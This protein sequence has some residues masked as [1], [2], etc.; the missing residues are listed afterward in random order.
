MKRLKIASHRKGSQIKQ[1][2]SRVAQNLYAR[3]YVYLNS[4]TV[5]FDPEFYISQYPDIAAAGIDPYRHFVFYGR[6]E[7]RVGE[8]PRLE[9]ADQILALDPRKETII[10]VSHEASRTG[11]PVLSLNLVMAFKQKYNVITMLLGVVS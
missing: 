2:A 5:D 8:S 3:A 11:A 1:A 4:S 6:R 9:S 7:G 10:V